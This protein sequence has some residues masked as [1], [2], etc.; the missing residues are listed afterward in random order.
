MP[1]WMAFLTLTFIWGSTPLAI[2]WSQ[3]GTG[4]SFAV[5]ARIAIGVMLFVLLIP[6]L[7]RRP[8][9]FRQL[10]VISVIAGLNL[11]GSMI[12][13]YWGARFLPSGWI[14]VLFGLGPMLTGLMAAFWLRE[15]FTR[16]HLLGSL[17]GFAGLLVIFAHA[18]TAGEQTPLGVGLVILS[19]C[20]AS[21]GNVAI[22][23][24]SRDIS[25]L[26]V[27]AGSLWVAFPLFLVVFLTSGDP[28]PGTVTLR[29]GLAIVYLG[30]V[31]NG[32]GFVCFY[33]LLS[34]V[35]AANAFLVTL[36]APAVA[37]WLGAVFNQEV[38][39]E[40]LLLGTILILV[41][42]ALFQWGIPW[43]IRSRRESV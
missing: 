3:Q 1:I 28:W 29:S 4:H 24:W 41:G 23:R 32:V 8:V 37:L 15:P 17:L 43:K 20:V 22:K 16:D 18:D 10:N 14:S 36:T 12:L 5:T 40:G 39:Q 34:R 35:S 42:L 7:K 31:A 2:Q 6:V 27:A 21:A 30:V 38:I 25:P 19:V 26:W 33:Y 11:F 9:T 13:L